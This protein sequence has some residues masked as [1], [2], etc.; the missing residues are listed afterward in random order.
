MNLLGE[1]DWDPATIY[2]NLVKLKESGITSVVSRAAG[3]DRYAIADKQE[4][5]VN[6]HTSFAM[7]AE[8]WRVSQVKSK[9][10]GQWTE[11]GL[12]PLKMQ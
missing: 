9:L 1:T 12:Q 6:T 7:I 2:R 3:I 11:P 10:K 5:I 8:K 4:E